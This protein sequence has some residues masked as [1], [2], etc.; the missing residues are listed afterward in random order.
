VSF[1]VRTRILNH[2]R[3]FWQLPGLET[4]AATLFG[5]SRPQSWRSRFLP[6]HDQFPQPSPRLVEM[7]DGLRFQVDVGT[8]LGWYLRFRIRDPAI[9][10]FF[11]LLD[12][13]MTV[14]DVGAN[15]GYTALTAAHIVGPSGQV[16]AF[17]PHATNYADLTRNLALNPEVSVT[18]FNL[19]L[20]RAQGEGS[21]EEP[22]ARNPGG[23]R[24][25]STG[26]GGNVQLES[27]DAVVRRHG[28][29]S[30]DVLKIDTEGFE[31]EVLLGAETVL[32]ED[33]PTIFLELSEGLLRHQGSSTIA[34]LGFLED[35][36]YLVGEAVTGRML[37]LDEDYEGCHCDAIAVPT[38]RRS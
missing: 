35:R 30:V 33:R 32:K 25:S 15:I 26:T 27:L 37:A 24:I 22:V 9:E 11:G 14:V 23:F 20:A 10:K 18:A 29:G 7:D 3:R 4:V 8:F 5:R 13:G 19:G 28:V 6:N 38:E 17:E 16:I 12:S 21:M 31:H 36:G 1:G 2:L 34:V